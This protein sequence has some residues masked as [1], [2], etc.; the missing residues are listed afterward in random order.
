MKLFSNVDN[1]AEFRDKYKCWVLFGTWHV[2]SCIL[3]PSLGKNLMFIVLRDGTGFLQCVLSDK[4]VPHSN[5]ITCLKLYDANLNIQEPCLEYV[6]CSIPHTWPQWSRNICTNH[7]LSLWW[8]KS[9]CCFCLQCQC[10][11]AL[12]LS[13]ESTVALYGMITT[14]PEGKQVNTATAYRR[15]WHLH[16]CLN[17]FHP[18]DWE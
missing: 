8:R 18:A 2:N 11:N 16:V 15:K 12:V 10:Y 9:D 5:S 13:T 3:F 17:R 7:N 6:I 14:V 1:I 4:L